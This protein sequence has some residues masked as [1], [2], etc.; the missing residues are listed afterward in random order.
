MKAGTMNEKRHKKLTD[1][2]TMAERVPV[3]SAGERGLRGILQELIALQM[4]NIEFK[5]ADA[6]QLIGEAV[7]SMP[8]AQVQQ[9]P[10]TTL[11]ILPAQVAPV[12]TPRQVVAQVMP[13]RPG[14]PDGRTV[15]GPPATQGNVP[16][17][18]DPAKTA[19]SI[20]AINAHQAGNTPP[21]DATPPPEKKPAA[22]PV[23]ADVAPKVEADVAADVPTA[24]V[25]PENANA[26][27]DATAA[28][29]AAQVD[30]AGSGPIISDAAMKS[31][32]A[33]LIAEMEA[34]EGAADNGKE[35]PEAKDEGLP[36]PA[37]LLTG[38]AG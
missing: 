25:T 30:A 18:P 29:L 36:D 19:A 21:A 10:N 3:V 8:P 15:P 4:G 32:E 6:R 11:A 7:L 24:T 35:Q 2:A 23:A 27:Q 5:A 20:A 1:L 28:D 26:E 16:Q 34:E 12:G 14:A 33:A 17:P 13:P 38:P 9:T 22:A 31:E 37:A